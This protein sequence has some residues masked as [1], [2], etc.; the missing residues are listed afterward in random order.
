MSN[1]PQLLTVAEAKALTHLNIR[2][3]IFNNTD[4]FA[5]R[6]VV[7]VGRAVRIRADRLAEFIEDRTGA[8]A[9]QYTYTKRPGRRPKSSGPSK[10]A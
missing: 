6:C 10:A 5:T 3:H 8:P 2:H 1:A 9:F 7:R 4:G